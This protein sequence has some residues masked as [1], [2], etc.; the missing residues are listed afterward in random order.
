METVRREGNT[1]F[2]DLTVPCYEVDSSL[3]LKP[4]SFMDMAQEIAYWAA[5]GLGFGYDDLQTHHTAWVLSRMHFHIDKAP[6][7]R[8]RVHLETWHKGADGLFYLRDFRLRSESGEEV[9]RCTSSW[10][11]INTETRHIVRPEALQEALRIEGAVAE[12]AIETPA[13]K[14][15]PTK[16]MQLE[17]VAQRTVSYSDVDV[18]S[19]TNNA[20]Y[21]LWAMDVLDFGLVSTKRVSD[22]EINFNKET[23]PGD[24]VEMFRCRYPGEPESWYVEGRV[25]GKPAFCAKITF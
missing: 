12:S 19:H 16:E 9:I 15:L 4:A 8:D 21:M 22:V 2:Q 24:V 6:Q 10:L 1:F 20:R 3:C 5:Q 17:A 11:I 18:L 23:R 25:G 14:I 7:W 13:A